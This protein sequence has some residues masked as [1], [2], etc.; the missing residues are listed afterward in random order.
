MTEPNDADDRSEL[1]AAGPSSL[2]RNGLPQE[3]KDSWEPGP[4][5]ADTWGPYYSA[6]FPPT[7]V[8]PWINFK[9]MG[10]GV[11]VVRRHWDQREELRAAYE[12]EHGS[13][14]D[15]WPHRHPGIVIDA[16]Q[17]RPCGVPGLPV[18]RPARQLDVGRGV[19]GSRRRSS[20][21]SRRFAQGVSRSTGPVAHA[22]RV[23]AR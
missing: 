2:R 5:Y 8:T 6:Q 23:I 7:K 12:A 11:N 21:P 4:G 16:V 9:R 14:P 22:A 18:D 19:A 10:S 1:E 13:D 15:N 3:L 17:C 20:A